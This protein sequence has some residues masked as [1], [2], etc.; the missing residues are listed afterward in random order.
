[1]LAA[2][3]LSTSVILP[4]ISWRFSGFLPGKV[5]LN[6]IKELASFFCGIDHTAI[7]VSDTETS[8]KFYRDTLGMQIA[9][10]SEN[11]GTE[12]EASQ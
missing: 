5:I 10:E 2:L 3:K 1:M 9:G 6:G 11:Y 4:G 7:M 12:Q 8:L